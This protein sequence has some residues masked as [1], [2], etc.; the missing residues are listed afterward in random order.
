MREQ[1]VVLVVDDQA[2]NRKLLAD[3]LATRGYAVE[4]AESGEEALTKIESVRPDLVL[5]DIVMPGLSGYD[6][7]RRIRADPATGVLP[8]VMV[9]A[10]DPAQERIKGLEAGADDFLT[11]PINTPEL[12]ARVKSLLRIKTFHDTVQTQAC[13]LAGL[14]ASLETRVQEQ[15]G[16]LQ[17]LAQLKRFF[18]PHLAERIVAGDVDDPLATHRREIAVVILDLRG[19]TAFAD[20]SEPEEV[21]SLLRR[22]HQVMGQLIQAHGGTLEQFSG[23][24]MLVI[25]NDPVISEDPAGHAVRMALEM[26]VRFDELMNTWRRRGHEISLGIGI[27]YGYATIGAI[28]DEARVGYGA[29]GRVTNLAARLSAEA[30][31]GQI[32]VSA[33]VYELVES[34]VDAEE[35]A[36]VNLSGFARPGPA[37]RIGGLKPK[38]AQQADVWPLKIY[39]LGQFALLREGEPVVFSRKVQKRPLDLLKALIAYGGV[40]ADISTLVASLWPDAEGDAARVSFDSNLHRLRKLIDIDDILPLSEGML[41]LDPARC[42]VDVWAFEGLVNRI[43]T[44]AHQPAESAEPHQAELAKELLRLYAGHFIETESQEP[45]AVATRDRLRAKFVRAISAVGAQLEQRRQWE[46]AV[47]LYSRALELDNLAEGLYRRLMISFRELGETAEASKVYRRCREM[48]S[49]VLS[50]SPSAE[51]E[52]IRAS[53]REGQTGESP[54]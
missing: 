53:L 18:P 31:A 29:I 13:E 34:L 25:F 23:G 28:G 7:C 19:F 41:S 27:A 37:Y 30:P 8:V 5:L 45:W 2:P 49:I 46:Q 22:N 3:L 6:V 33:S 11:K 10:L 40:R 1:P 9:T 12:L 44:T 4:T 51:T 21:M 52:A 42:W 48:L 54:R 32:L 50:I 26:Q 36:Q 24:S 35:A 39:T 47:A 15:L 14:N 16:E 17:R 20:A 38:R 43:E